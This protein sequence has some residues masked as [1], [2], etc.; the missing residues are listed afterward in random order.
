MQLKKIKTYYLAIFSNFKFHVVKQSS[1]FID[2]I[3]QT[4]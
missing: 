3:L 2:V 1:G 4:S